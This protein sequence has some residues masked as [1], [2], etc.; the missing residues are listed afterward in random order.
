MWRGPGAL[1]QLERRSGQIEPELVRQP[2]RERSAS[3]RSDS[4]EVAK[5]KTMHP[6]FY[7]SQFPYWQFLVAWTASGKLEFH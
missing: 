3:S 4:P 5:T 2:E 6:Y 1:R 7:A